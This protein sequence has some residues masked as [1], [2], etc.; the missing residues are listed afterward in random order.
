MGEIAETA[1]LGEVISR[2]VPALEEAWRYEGPE[3]ATADRDRWMA[4]LDRPLPETG[5]GID[6]VVDELI[7]Y[8][9]PYGGRVGKPGF[10]SWVTTGPTTVGVAAGLAAATTSP[11]RYLLTASNHLE[12][13]SLRWLQELLEIPP[14]H[15]GVYSS[16]GSVANL[17]GLGAARQAAYEARGR[18]PSADG[19]DGPGR[20]YTSTEAHHTVARSAAVLGL[21]RNSVFSAPVDEHQ[22]VKVDVLADAVER[23]IDSDVVPVAIVASAGTTNTGA[24]DPIDDLAELAE[25]HDVWLHVD[26]AYGL[27]AVADPELRPRFAG[28]ERADSVIVD[29]H[30]WLAAP[31]GIGAT[32][33][34]DA[35][36]LYRAFT[37]G[38][39][40][41]LEGSFRGEAESPFD[42]L[43]VRYDEFGVELS[44]PA[45]GMVVWALL[46]ELGADGVGAVVRRDVGHARHLADRAQAEERLELVTEPELS[47]CCFRYRP[48][49]GLVED[50]L[51]DL[52]SRILDRLRR[53]TRYAPSSTVVDGRYALRPCYI[54]PRTTTADVDGLADA[55]LAIGDELAAAGKAG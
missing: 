22:R 4:A 43:G 16:G 39:A 12:G 3:T 34:R 19:I 52:N 35:D 37:Q 32:F 29:P 27:F 26:G 7:D 53:D 47:I 46:R 2:L 42:D 1:R 5:V 10:S 55:V 25:R 9:V 41:Y 51:T 44:A 45:R 50:E 15:Q 30:K 31:V 18:D 6:Q 49:R 28:I 38:P 48:R 21:G 24:I 20:I 36:L 11:Q 40:D 17:V 14:G 13:Q 33:V 54:N 23:D 8:V